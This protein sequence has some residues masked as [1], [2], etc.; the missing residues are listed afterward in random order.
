MEA[1]G[2]WTWLEQKP[3]NSPADAWNTKPP[4]AGPVRGNP[5]ATLSANPAPLP[6]DDDHAVGL[7]EAHQ[8]HLPDIAVAALR[9][10]RAN[11]RTFPNRSTSEAPN[12][13]TALAISSAGART[14]PRTA[15]GITN[16][17]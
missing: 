7:R 9:Y 1:T 10:A 12:S 2:C 3:A 16:L 15:T 4:A 5:A 8:H 6:V 13:S 17:D 11:D 14:R